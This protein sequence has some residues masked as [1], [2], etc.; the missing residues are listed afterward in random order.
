MFLQ[1]VAIILN[2]F[3]KFAQGIKENG[4]Y[5]NGNIP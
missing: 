2:F 4:I 3:G 5:E 1:S